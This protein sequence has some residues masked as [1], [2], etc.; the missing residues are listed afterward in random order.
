MSETPSSTPR[1]QVAEAIGCLWWLP[2]LRGIL[3]LVLG[4]YSL[5]RPGMTIAVLA[6]VIGIF[7]I[8]EG[9]LCI[10][11]GVMGEVPSRIWI[12]VRGVVEILVG[13]FVF[14]NPILVAGVTG[15]FLIYMLAFTA[16]LSG[17]FEIMAAIQDRKQIEGEGWLILG[18]ALTVMFGVLVLI[19][20]IAFG[21]VMVRILGIF[22][23]IAGMSLIVFA[24]RL[25]SLGKQMRS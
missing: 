2:L 7:V 10:L 8:A 17:I 12:I 19:S 20:P 1:Q 3:L 11:A 21:L 22:A 18:G 13:L 23:I 16:I 4:G 15:T 14:A 5:F 6:Q 24:F 25:R 9:V